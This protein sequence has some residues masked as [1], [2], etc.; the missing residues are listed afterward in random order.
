MYIHLPADEH[1]AYF[2]FLAILNKHFAQ[3]C[4]EYSNTSVFVDT[5]FHLSWVNT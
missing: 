5:C 2:Q 3:N 4:Y 1:L